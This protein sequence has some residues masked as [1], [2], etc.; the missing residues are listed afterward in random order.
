VDGNA[1]IY[2]GSGVY[3][4]RDTQN[5]YIV[6]DNLQ[7][8]VI[9]I[10]TDL[11]PSSSSL[12]SIRNPAIS[13]D[14]EGITY[15]QYLNAYFVV[16]EDIK[17]V[18]PNRYRARILSFDDTFHLKSKNPVEYIFHVDNSGFEGIS[19]VEK[20][21]E[22]YVLALCEGN[23]CEPKGPE[24]EK[25]GTILVLKFNSNLFSE[26][27]EWKVVA[28][29]SL[30]QNNAGFSDYAGMDVFQNQ[31]IAVVSQEDSSLWVG[32]LDITTWK[33]KGEGYKTIFPL[34]GDEKMQFCNVEGISWIT[35]DTI[36][37]TTDSSDA[38]KPECCPYSQSISIFNVHWETNVF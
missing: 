2:E 19:T 28:S 6:C 4:R 35:R 7:N 33:I 20:N 38:D 3:Y 26:F 32:E 34:N 21:G 36:V 18:A 12:I 9:M 5:Y 15:N 22:I 10:N 1:T 29:I 37:V 11:S 27:G 24:F 16:T 14:F 30:P 8:E 25:N 23:A 31:W 17:L 13:E